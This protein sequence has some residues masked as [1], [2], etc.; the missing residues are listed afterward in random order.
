VSRGAKPA[1]GITISYDSKRPGFHLLREDYLRAVELA[2][3]LPL[4]L[5]PGRPADAPELIERLDGLLLSGG[6][7]IDPD[8][9]HTPA[10][11]VQRIFQAKAPSHFIERR[12]VRKRV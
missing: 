9:V 11:F 3:G 8:L 7:D 4:V 6:G 1:I 5:A 2:G 10:I 12:T